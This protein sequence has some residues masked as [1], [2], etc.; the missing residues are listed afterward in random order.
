[1]IFCGYPVF[2]LPDIRLESKP[3]RIFGATIG[4]FERM[5]ESLMVII[6]FDLRTCVGCKPGVS[7]QIPSQIQAMQVQ[8]TYMNI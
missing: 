8:P 6:G 5:N 7:I 4:L 1:M 2:G 3:G